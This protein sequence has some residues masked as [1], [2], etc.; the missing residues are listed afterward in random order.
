M[1]YVQGTKYPYTT[2]GKAAAK[3]A[4]AG[5]LAAGAVKRKKNKAAKALKDAR[6][7][8]KNDTIKAANAM[9]KSS[10]RKVQARQRMK[11]GRGYQ[12]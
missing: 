1:P 8:A 9:R 3:K 12:K 10:V 11:A 4:G 6:K 2:A 5:I 7:A